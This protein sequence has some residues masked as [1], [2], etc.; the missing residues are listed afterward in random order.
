MDICRW[1]HHERTRGY[2]F[3]IDI[4]LWA[5]I[6]PHRYMRLGYTERFMDE[7]V[8]DGCVIFPRGEGD[9]G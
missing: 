4:D 7:H 5:D 9:G 3:A 2:D 6:L 8:K 1:V